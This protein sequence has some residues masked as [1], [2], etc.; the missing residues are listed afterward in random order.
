VNRSVL[1]VLLGVLELV[2]LSY[3]AFVIW[4][5]EALAAVLLKRGYEARG[6]TQPRLVFRLRL[7][8]IAGVALALAAVGIAATKVVG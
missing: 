2:A 7:L 4:R 1:M 6:W 8:G 3:F 5:A